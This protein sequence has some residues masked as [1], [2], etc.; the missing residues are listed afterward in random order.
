MHLTGTIV[1]MRVAYCFILLL[2]VLNVT[3]QNALSNSRT[4]GIQTQVYQLTDKETEKLIDDPKAV[5]DAFFHTLVDTYADPVKAKELPYG[6]YLRLMPV[7][8]KLEYYLITNNNVTLAFINNQKEFQFAVRDLW[9]NVVPQAKVYTGKGRQLAYHK[10]R[11]LY[12]S[13]YPK[14]DGFIKV[15]HNGVSNYFTYEA[16][17]RAG[18]PSYYRDLPFGRKVISTF[19]VKNIRRFFIKTRNRFRNRPASTSYRSFMVFSKPQ[20]KPY[21]TVKFKAYLLTSKGAVVKARQAEVWM[22]NK[23]GYKKLATIRPYNDGAFEYRFVLADSLDLKLDA[24]YSISLVDSAV[25]KNPNLVSGSFRYEDYE[26]KS[27][28]FNVR[29][30]KTMHYPGSPVNLFMKATDENELAV[31]DARVEIVLRTQNI[32]EFYDAAVFVKDTL[33]TQNMNLDP[34]GETKL[35]LPDSIFPNA[36]LSFMVETRMLN[37]NNE[38]RTATEYLS[39][40]ARSKHLNNEIITTFVKDSLRFTYKEAGQEKQQEGWLYANAYNDKVIDSQ[41]VQLPHSALI[42]YKAE[43]YYLK[44]DNGIDTLISYYDFEPGVKASARQKEKELVLLVANPH[45]IPFWYTVFS[46]NKVLTKGY[47]HTLD[48]TIKHSSKQAAHL[49][50]NYLWDD[51]EKTEEVSTFYNANELNIKLLAPDVVY[52]GQKVNMKVRVVNPKEKP[53]EGVDVTAYAHTAK[54]KSAT[55]SIPRFGKVFYN[56]KKK[57]FGFESDEAYASSNIKMNWNK[58]GSTLGLDTIEYYRFTHPDK[59][60]ITEETARDSITQFAPFVMKDG[61]FEPVSILYI[62]ELPVFYYEAQQLQ[63]YAFAVTPGKHSIKMRTP[64]YE[65]WIKEMYF[66]KGV[67]TVFSVLADTTNTQAHVVKK[68]NVLSDVE[69]ERLNR[70][71]IRVMD[72]FE[73]EKTFITDDTMKLWLNPPPLLGSRGYDRLIGPL[74]QNLLYFQTTGVNQSFF[75]EP[76][77]TYTFS[78]GLIRQKS[79]RGLY[80]FDTILSATYPL[81]ENY[82]Q[83]VLQNKEYDS[84]W[85]EFLNLRSRTTQLYK[86]DLDPDT[87]FGR[88]QY[89]IDTVFTNK[90][91]YIKNIL[92]SNPA[93]PHQLLILNGDN[94]FVQSLPAGVY[95]IL[96]LL[97]DNR[98]FRTSHISVYPQGVN[99]YSWKSFKVNAADSFSIKLDQTIKS[100]KHIRQYT[101]QVP[102]EIVRQFNSKDFDFSTLKKVMTGRVIDAGTKRP[103]AGVS[104]VIEGTTIG[105]V[106]DE[107][108][109][110]KIKVPQK[111]KV[112]VSMIGYSGETIPAQNGNAG[113][114]VLTEA[115]NQLDE[116]VVVG[117]GT[118]RRLSVTGAV[119]TVNE[120]SQL[121][122][123][124]QGRVAGVSVTSEGRLSIRGT[125]S[126]NANN[127]PLIIID[128]IPFDGDLESLAPNDINELT[129]ITAEDAV[130]IYGSRGA[131]GVVVIKTKQG[132]TLV[133]EAGQM[134]QGEQRLRTRFSDEGFWIPALTTDEHGEASFTVTFPDDVTNWKTRVIAINGKKQSGY[135]ETSIKSFKTLSANFVAPLFAVEGDSMTVMG[136]L[137]NYT[138]V[139]EKVSRVLKFNNSLLRNDSLTVMNAHIDTTLIAVTG[140]DSLHFEYTLQQSNGYFDGE[141]RKLPVYTA[142]VKET[143]GGFFYMDKDSVLNYTFEKD[144]GPGT[145]RAEASVFP[146]LLDEMRKLRDYEYLCNEQLAS[147]LKSLLLEKKLRGY[148]KEPFEY[149]KYIPA[150]IKKLNENKSMQNLW[151]WWQGAHEETWISLHVVE[152]LLQAEAQ[153]YKTQL[154]KA[155]LYRYLLEKVTDAG[156]RADIKMVQLLHILDG[157]HNIK[158]WVQ[159]KEADPTYGKQK[160]TLYEWL[161]LQQLRQMAGLPV[162]IDSL[163][164]LKK[165]SMFGGVYWGEESYYFWNNSIQ[166][167]LLVYRILKAAGG[168]EAVLTKIRQYFLEQRRDGQWRNTYESS[169]ILE[170]IL[171]DLFKGD[172]KPKPASILVNGERINKFPFEKRFDGSQKITV[173]KEGDMPIYFTAYQQFQN[174]QPQK[175]SK[176]FEVNSFFMQ[177]GTTVKELKAGKTAILRVE[178]TAR[179]DA[180]YVMVEVPIPAGCSYENKVQRFWGVE[181]HREYFKNKTSIFCT[182]LKQGK[183]IFDIELMPRYNGKYI[184]NPAKAEMMYFPVFYGRE[185]MKK[186]GIE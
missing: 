124:L 186:V 19:P 147:K 144:K 179:A 29:T 46:G 56:R 155:I 184:L 92:I 13:W 21:D 112:T 162:N 160:K 2:Y 66:K 118:T 45:K 11:N 47:T 64:G 33:W 18:R 77:Y 44:L 7:K 157:S 177:N 81:A 78:P 169:L 70:Y 24:N 42:N 90:L 74:K 137:M 59:L 57:P 161:Q 5:T 98:Y 164:S 22:K 120:S 53:V 87:T 156:P 154:N 83:Q 34:V 145:I 71:M 163:L 175:V 95:D 25:R 1:Y 15:V 79:Y 131:N 133:N 114:I 75:K 63:N 99:Y 115:G 111:G 12:K 80:A 62:D 28:S 54:F 125:S 35:T 119:S 67:K 165:A 153:G 128:G 134:V 91:P 126:L 58:W 8:N 88:L 176:D 141:L 107:N 121:V 174:R 31:P 30:D 183:Y 171:P 113:D 61:D 41:R 51:E 139:P 140:T 172:A 68:K 73:G 148:L 40:D 50:I 150:V 55:P 97:Q 158:D 93:K 69:A 129:V 138:P 16:D 36:A 65:V 109:Y 48:T 136:K 3:A 182:Q 135:L 166:N 151:G 152:A 132:N 170:T 84:I 123:V 106:T 181:T 103:I 37:S 27:L 86:N 173:Y 6:N 60:Y 94:T 100:E 146:V 104:V 167:T 76:G 14:E 52:P 9:G 180:E 168:H 159:V 143:V 127:K 38:S 130:A 72:N 122:S 26:L 10:K 82:K 23:S 89:A 142:G 149:E 108:G 105:V 116:V 178:V 117:Y 185:G 102:K 96:F 39:Y 49:R 101:V 4:S 110:F 20:Y 17:D 32:S 43:G 85:N